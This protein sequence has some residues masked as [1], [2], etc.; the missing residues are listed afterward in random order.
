MSSLFGSLN[1]TFIVRASCSGN[2]L[3]D[4]RRDH[5]RSDAGTPPSSAAVADVREDAVV[6]DHDRR[7][8]DVAQM[9]A[10]AELAVV[11]IAGQAAG[12]HAR[13]SRSRRRVRKR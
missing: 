1:A 8:Q 9:A 5:S 10:E 12:P 3:L 6:V 7:R 13:S 11:A 4:M 2:C